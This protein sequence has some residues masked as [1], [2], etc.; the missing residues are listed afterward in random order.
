[1]TGLRVLAAAVFLSLSAWSA[2]AQEGCGDL[3]ACLRPLAGEVAQILSRE[4]IS[5]GERLQVSF[6]PAY[7][8]S[9][10]VSIYCRALSMGL[11]NALNEEVGDVRDGFGLDFDVRPAPRSRVEPPEVAATWE[12]ERDRAALALE[13][14]V[15]LPER[16]ER[17]A[18]GRI[19][20][21]AL[22]RGERACL[23]SF[24]AGERWIEAEAPGVLREEPTFRADAEVAEYERGEELRV[25]GRIEAVDGSGGV[26][27]VVAWRDPVTRERRNLFATG[28]GS[29]SE[30]RRLLEEAREA[31]DAAWERARS[32]DT[33]SAYADYLS[34]YA[35]GL[36]VSEARRLLEEAQVKEAREADDAAWERARS[37]DTASGYAD[38][39][40]AYASGLH[41]SEARRLRDA[42]LERERSRAVDD[43]AW[44]RARS[45]DTASAYA[46]YLSAHPSGRHVS[47]ARRL[48]DAALERER[49]PAV[50]DIFRDC[51]D[52]P[53]M[54]VVPSGSFMMGSPPS[55]E[56]RDDDEGPVHRVTIGA[57]F[58]VGV[59]EVTRGEFGRFVS[60]T[61]RSMGNG[62]WTYEDGEGEYR[63]GRSW[64]SPG[65]SQTDLHPAVCVS[66]DDAQAYV[67]WLSRETGEAYR[68]LSESEWEYVARAGTTTRYHW[69]DAIGRNLA[70]C[71][72]C[73][74]RWDGGKGTSPVGSFGANAFGLHDVHGNV[75]EFV[76]DCVNESYA[77][78][79]RDGSAWKGGDCS[80]HVLRGG[81]WYYGPRV[82]RAA[83]RLRD[84]TGDRLNVVGFRVARTFT[85]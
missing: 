7:M 24:A 26:W 21:A 9:L 57:R 47:E 54:V 22:S 31:D 69:G 23:F 33:A 19:P 41:V 74:S 40:S 37:S 65:F 28:L 2:S 34:A 36:H 80:R 62:C 50:G 70:N 85:P 32:S 68:L 17:R 18:S 55:E 84:D 48:R 5:R 63:S 46:D 81:S 56:G 78:A 6:R 8:E 45:S 4:A 15:A 11:R 52:C 38:Y 49:G 27:S 29:F 76:E 66:R 53:A 35:S 59:Y 20:A 73:G 60:S 72:D 3:R 82:L 58:A 12:W 25:L 13:V 39:L 67:D 10:G 71:W 75:L 51:A 64:L 42:A 1:M 44:E 14:H 61:G 43:A 30:A 77:G 79:P 16:R 83:D